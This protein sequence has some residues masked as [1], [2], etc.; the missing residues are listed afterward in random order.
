MTKPLSQAAVIRHT[1]QDVLQLFY[2]SVALSLFLSL[3]VSHKQKSLSSFIVCIL[4]L[5]SP[6]SSRLILLSLNSK[7]LKR[8]DFFYYYSYKSLKRQHGQSSSSQAAQR[9]LNRSVFCGIV[10]NEL[11]ASCDCRSGAVMCEYLRRTGWKWLC[12]LRY[13]MK[14]SICLFSAGLASSH[15]WFTEHIYWSSAHK[16][17]CSASATQHAFRVDFQWSAIFCQKW[18]I[19]WMIHILPFRNALF[20]RRPHWTLQREK[21]RFS[22]SLCFLYHW[23]PMI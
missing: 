6:R 18:S 11:W 3:S 2:F 7:H 10:G 16:E 14:C 8:A 4:F 17:S 12:W 22:L 13:Q 5:F 1:H 9:L 15:L 20:G 21:E 23:P 19:R